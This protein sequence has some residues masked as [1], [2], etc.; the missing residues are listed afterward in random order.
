MFGQGFGSFVETLVYV[1]SNG[2]LRMG[3]MTTEHLP[4][5]LVGYDGT[6]AHTLSLGTWYYLVLTYNATVGLV[7][8]VNGAVDNT[9]APNNVLNLTSSAWYVG[10]QRS[11]LA[12]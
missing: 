2:K 3:V 9:V 1:K 7:G 4:G 6:G 12:G 8:Y 11:F 10:G 5:A